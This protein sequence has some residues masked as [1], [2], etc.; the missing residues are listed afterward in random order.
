MV[1]ISKK[2]KLK[3][4]LQ[5]VTVEKNKTLLELF[6]TSI[7]FIFSVVYKLILIIRLYFYQLG[8]FPVYKSC[9]KVISVGNI[10]VGG[11]GKTPLVAMIAEFLLERKQKVAIISRGYKAMDSE[12]GLVADEPLMLT[13]QLPEANIIISRNRKQAIIDLEKNSEDNVVILDDAFQNCAI[14]KTLDI[15]CISC[16]N[17]FGNGHI[18]PRGIMRLPFAYLKRAD[19]FV[20]THCVNADIDIS[21]T[22]D[23]LRRYNRNALICKTKHVP[24]FFY[25]FY[26]NEQQSLASIRDKKIAIV[27]GISQPDN[28]NNMLESLGATI[29]LRFYFPDHYNFSIEQIKN[30]FSDCLAKG[31]F[32]LVTT[33]KDEPRLKLVLNQE[34]FASFNLQILVL[35]IRIN[36]EENEEGFAARLSS[37]FTA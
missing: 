1:G 19:I 32:L 22:L 6:L 2:E 31:I 18:I 27:C 33:A 7:L 9:L 36:L 37:I 30:I 12:L 20:L 16:L 4:Y 25:D 29:G 23:V 15:V 17:P 11:T 13:K 28:F 10:T 35:K 26:S 8:L 34:E 21:K 24:E 14:E 3:E 5:R